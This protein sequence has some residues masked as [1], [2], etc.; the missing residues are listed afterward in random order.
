[1]FLQGFQRLAQIVRLLGNHHHAEILIVNGERHAETVDD[2]P[3]RRR[4]HLQVDAVLF[5]E[6]LVF[7]T[8]DHL[9]PRKTATENCQ[10]TSLKSAD[11]EGPA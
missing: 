6:N 11:D 2:L 9:Q 7:V 1:M 4:H 5:G 8:F 10:K 3:A